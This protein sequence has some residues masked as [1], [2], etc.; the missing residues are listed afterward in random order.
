MSRF[1]RTDQ[2]KL[3]N[4]K[5]VIGIYFDAERIA[6]VKQAWKCQIA[7]EGD[8][9]SYNLR[10][11]TRKNVRDEKGGR[12]R[13]AKCEKQTNSELRCKRRLNKK[14]KFFIGIL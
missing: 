14:K 9:S 3:A 1:S 13:E 7:K 4:D 2:P 12:A 6:A 8:E 11:M 5:R 10:S